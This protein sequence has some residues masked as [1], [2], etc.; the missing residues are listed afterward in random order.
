MKTFGTRNGSEKLFMASRAVLEGCRRSVAAIVS[1]VIE[2]SPR[3]FED[4]SHTLAILPCFK[5]PRLAP[6]SDIAHPTGYLKGTTVA[7][8]GFPQYPSPAK[9]R[10]MKNCPHPSDNQKTMH[11]GQSRSLCHATK[12]LRDGEITVQSK[13]QRLDDYQYQVGSEV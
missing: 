1:N 12:R 13:L 11:I 6:E 7:D 2:T 8:F 3:S 5:L 9:L 4:L 10:R